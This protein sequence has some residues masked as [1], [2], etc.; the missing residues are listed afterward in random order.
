MSIS[1]NWLLSD[2]VIYSR[3]DGDVSLEDLAYLSNSVDKLCQQTPAASIHHIIDLTRL[4][5]IPLNLVQIQAATRSD[6]PNLKL[7]WLIVLHTGTPI[8]QFLLTSLSHFFNFKFRIFRTLEEG[9]EFLHQNDER[10]PAALPILA[11]PFHP[12]PESPER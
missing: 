2:Q 8:I 6:Q 11:M 5:K 12:V 3:A 10:L 7:V 1:I 9:W 4:G